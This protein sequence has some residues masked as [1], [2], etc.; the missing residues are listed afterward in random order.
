MRR[1]TLAALA[2]LI[3]VPALASGQ[4]PLAEATAAFRQGN[5]SKA[6]SLFERAADAERDPAARA[7][8]RVKLAWTYFAMKQRSKAEEALAQALRDAPQ[9]ELAAEYYTADFMKL[10]RRVNQQATAAPAARAATP[11]LVQPAAIPGSLAALRQKLALA[12]D[13]PAL[14]A[15]LGEVKAL[16]ASTPQASLPD[17][18]ELEADAF[19]RLGRMPDALGLRGRAAAL[20]AAALASPGSPVVPLDAL[21]EARRLIASNRAPEAAA[22]MNGVLSTLPTCVPALEVL[23]EALMESGRLD[24]ASSVLKTAL[25]NNE[26]PEL[27]M[28]LGAVELRRKN[29]NAARDAFRRAASLD[30]SNDQA[31]ASL[32]LLAASLGDIASAREALDKA[33]QLNGTLFEARVVRAEI[34]LKDGDPAAAAQQ[35]QRALQVHPDDAWAN[36]WAGVASLAA[37]NPAAALDRLRAAAKAQPQA[38]TLPLAE[39]LR[40]QGRGQ[41]A[42]ALLSGAPAHDP[43]TQLVRARCLLD[44]GRAG[45]AVPILEAMVRERPDDARGHCLLAYAY[46]TQREWQRAAQE[47]AR[48]EKLPG[49]PAFVAQSLAFA[50]ATVQAQALMDGAAAPRPVPHR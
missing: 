41:E 32:G 23:G 25:L 7:D 12:E 42:L 45:D 19:E 3:L 11:Q 43:E 29:Y 16:E 5:L 36:G 13:P 24:E 49:A 33:L 39:A 6:A 48:A 14:E 46:H 20:R 26:K 38:F 2:I 50:Q 15:V 37:G 21:L 44:L 31:W 8:I 28:N 4:D 34:A 1:V 30:D 27:L 10:F 47:L 35:L 9:L 40:R 17:V 18:L 22:L